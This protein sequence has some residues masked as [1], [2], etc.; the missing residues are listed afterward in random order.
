MN[1]RNLI[2]SFQFAF[3]GLCY[4]LKTQ[5]NI[6]I[7]FI[8]GI[9]AILAGFALKLSAIE[10]ALLSCAIVFVLMAEIINTAIEYSLDFINGRKFDPTVRIIKD[11]FAGAVLVA[12]INALI[13]GGII[14]LP[15]IL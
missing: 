4:T 3:R 2:Q 12:S 1:S 8:L 15:H 9:T 13:V 11:I 14:F 5:R 6:R 10:M 7:H